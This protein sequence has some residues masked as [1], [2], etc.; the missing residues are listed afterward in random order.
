MIDTDHQVGLDA[1]RDRIMTWQPIQQDEQA[2]L[3]PTVPGTVGLAPAPS[4]WPRVLGM[5]GIILGALGILG[6]L[7]GMVS[8]LFVSFM[9]S[10]MPPG[11]ERAFEA[12]EQMNTWTVVG[13]ILG[14]LVAGL[15]LA[16][17]I[18]LLRRRL[19]GLGCYGMWAILKILLVAVNAGIALSMQ[20]ATMEFINSSNP[21]GPI[22][23]AGFTSVM[24]VIVPAST[25]IWGWALPVFILIWLAR[26]KIKAETAKWQ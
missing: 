17:G 11:A 21:R 9:G 23:S 18:G 4:T 24:T 7:W 2:A 19:W 8:P 3:P 16:G 14:L 1:A 12:A 20:E 15:L 10:L 25:L 22:I 26:V 5:I 13:S 6:G